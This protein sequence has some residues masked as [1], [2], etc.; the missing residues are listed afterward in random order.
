MSTGVLVTGVGKDFQSGDWA[1]E[2]SSASSGTA[3]FSWSL[4]KGLTY[5]DIT[6]GA[7]T[8]TETFR[9]ILPDCKIKVVITGDTLDV[10]YRRI[11]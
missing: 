11:V 2:V 9:M 4:D 7:Y 8:A 6:D 1:F 3:T 5:V 10:K